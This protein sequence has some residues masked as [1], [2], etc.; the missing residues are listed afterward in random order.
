MFLKQT[1]ENIKHSENLILNHN[2]ITWGGEVSIIPESKF[3]KKD[4]IEDLIFFHKRKEAVRF[5]IKAR[6]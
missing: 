4:I 5:S 3:R 2:T 1:V 6:K